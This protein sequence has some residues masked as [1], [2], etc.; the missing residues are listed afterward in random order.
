M[1]H[2]EDMEEQPFECSQMGVLWLEGTARSLMH[3]EE[4][5]TN[6]GGG[7]DGEGETERQRLR[8]KAE[9]EYMG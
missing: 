4:R 2:R 9:K 5:E 6:W 1:G 7:E 3:L 8:K